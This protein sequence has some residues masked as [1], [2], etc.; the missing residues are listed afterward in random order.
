MIAALSP[1][2]RERVV[3]V[4]DF[5]DTEAPSILDAC[6]IVTLPSV[7]ESFGMAMI[8]AWACGKP[9]IGGDIASTRCIID[10]GVDGWLVT[11]FDA[12]DLA[13]RILDLIDNPQQ[14]ADFGEHGRAKVLERYTWDHVADS[15]EATFHRVVTGR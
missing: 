4:D 12:S 2:D 15:W 5:P 11:P 1:A 13:A 7:E 3:L 6:D 14:R 9:V 8:E 10:A